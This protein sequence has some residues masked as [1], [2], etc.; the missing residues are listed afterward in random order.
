MKCSVATRYSRWRGVRGEGIY[1]TDISARYTYHMTVYQRRSSTASHARTLTFNASNFRNDPDT[2]ADADADT[3][4]THNINNNNNFNSRCCSVHMHGGNVFF[5]DVHNI[6]K[7]K[8]SK[9]GHGSVV[10]A[11]N[12][13]SSKKSGHSPKC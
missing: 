11:L 12:N 10:S 1:E 4:S 8:E 2:D 13:K 5:P 9:R 7:K 3:H 6:G